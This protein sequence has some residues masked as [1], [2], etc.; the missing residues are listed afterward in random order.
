MSH[1]HKK[2]KDPLEKTI[3]AK[4]NK[5]AKD[6]YEIL[7]YKFNSEARRSVPDR[8]YIPRSAPIFFIEYKRWGQKPTGG[9]KREISKIRAQGKDVFVVDNV[10]D[11]ITI[12]D[13]AVFGIPYDVIMASDVKVIY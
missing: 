5:H 10:V 12:I 13:L 7:Q 4:C 3:E 11:G 8:I 6:E 1:L 9:Q 2:G